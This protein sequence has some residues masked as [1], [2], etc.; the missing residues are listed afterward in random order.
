MNQL[1]LFLFIV[2]LNPCESVCQV[3]SYKLVQDMGRGL[4]LG[5]VLSAPIEGNWAPVVYEQYFIDVKNEGFSNVRI[6][7]DFYGNRTSGSTDNFSTSAGTESN[8]NGSISDFTVD[9]NYLDRLQTIVD[10]SMG[11]SLYTVIDFHGAQLK[12]EFLTTFNSNEP[13]YTS[14]SSS[15]RASD[16]MKFK[17]IWTTIAVIIIVFSSFISSTLNSKYGSF[18]TS[19]IR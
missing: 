1:Y 19:K 9:Q 14:P 6:P 4:N 16:L 5:N 15:K 13:N 8:Y 12:S 18:T 3:S 11:Q 10:W 2:F 17:S 7:V